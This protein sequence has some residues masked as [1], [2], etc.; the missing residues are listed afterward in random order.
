MR[1]SD[2]VQSEQRTISTLETGDQTRADLAIC[3]AC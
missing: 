3:F 2:T 1:H